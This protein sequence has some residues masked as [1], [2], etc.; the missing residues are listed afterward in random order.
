NLRLHEDTTNTTYQALAD[1]V[2]TLASEFGT[3]TAYMTPEILAIPQE[4]LD[5]F[6]EQEPRL[7]VYR[8]ALDE[9]NRERPH[10]LPAEQQALLAPASEIGNA[11]E[12]IYEMLTSADL[13]LPVVRDENG[14]EVQLT[15]GNYVPRFLETRDRTVRAAA[16]ESMLGTYYAYV[17]T[18]GT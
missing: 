9:I 10:I 13:K 12:R 8:H 15:Q 4:Q 18:F 6:L 1:R 3:A 7:Q 17:N 16:F 11:P 2:T 14:D 5:R